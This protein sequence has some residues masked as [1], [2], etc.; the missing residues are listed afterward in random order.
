MRGHFAVEPFPHPPNGPFLLDRRSKLHSA[1]L[2]TSGVEVH[3][4]KLLEHLTS[5]NFHFLWLIVQLIVL[6]K[7]IP[8]WHTDEAHHRPK[9]LRQLGNSIRGQL[10][11]LHPK[12]DQNIIKDKLRRHTEPSCEKLFK[13]NGF[14]LHLL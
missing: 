10:V 11:E 8:V 7:T 2:V 6:W 14:I 13:H 4:A 12:F 5:V 3:V 9:V 1:A